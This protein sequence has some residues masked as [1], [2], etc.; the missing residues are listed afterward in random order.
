MAGASKAR[1][2]LLSNLWNVEAS[3][4]GERMMERLN[5]VV[6]YDDGAALRS[7]A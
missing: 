3:G 4:R 6:V 2:G 1:S 5:R 7:V